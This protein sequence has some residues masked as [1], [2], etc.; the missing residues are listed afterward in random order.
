M[1]IALMVCG[2][3]FL[4][5]FIFGI[6]ILR[7]GKNVK[8]YR[9]A[10]T[11]FIIGIIGLS[12]IV[13][14]SIVSYARN[15][16]E[17]SNVFDYRW[18]ERNYRPRYSFFTEIGSITTKTKD[19]NSN[20]TVKVEMIIGY[21]IGDDITEKELNTKK[22]LIRDFVNNYFSEKYKSELMPEYEEELKKEMLKIINTSILNS[23]R[24][25]IIIFNQLDVIGW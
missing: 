21:S 14:L 18:D 1:V 23:G 16:Y 6:I 10:R 15:R 22:D 4:F 7:K 19:I 3:V 2:I 5:V 9:L 11:G 25:R 24:V 12:I 20:F 17:N 8:Y 13:I